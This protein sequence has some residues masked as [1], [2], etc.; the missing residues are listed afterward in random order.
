VLARSP[1]APSVPEEALEFK[2]LVERLAERS[3]NE[4]VKTVALGTAEKCVESLGRLAGET[5]AGVISVFE[6]VVFYCREAYLSAKALTTK[7]AE[8]KELA[9]LYSSVMSIAEEKLYQF[10]RK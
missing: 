1:S 2:R 7:E 9:K 8:V 10:F 5:P 4:L 6:D 3:S